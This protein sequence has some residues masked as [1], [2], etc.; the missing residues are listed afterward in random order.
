MRRR[1]IVLFHEPSVFKTE[2]F[3][4]AV[5]SRVERSKNWCMITAENRKVVDS[6]CQ[7]G[8]TPFRIS[9]GAVESL[10]HWRGTESFVCLGV[11]RA[12]VTQIDEA[13]LLDMVIESINTP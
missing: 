2:R 7:V 5:A 8:Q 4:S 3:V 1:L 12:T 13:T 6:C 11:C 9:K 10:K